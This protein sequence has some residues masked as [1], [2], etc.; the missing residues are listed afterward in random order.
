MWR[1]AEYP[2]AEDRR[3]SSSKGQADNKQQRTGGQQAAEDGRDI[4]QQRTGGTSSSRGQTGHQA[5]KIIQDIRGLR[6]NGT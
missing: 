6:T 3:T 2:A 4:K 1:Q 5:S